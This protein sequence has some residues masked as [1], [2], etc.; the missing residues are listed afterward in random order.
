MRINCLVYVQIFC[1]LKGKKIKDCCRQVHS[2]AVC[3]LSPNSH[4]LELSLD[5]WIITKWDYSKW[6]VYVSRAVAIICSRH[7]EVTSGHWVLDCACS[8]TGSWLRAFWCLFALMESCDLQ[9]FKASPTKIFKC[10]YP[11]ILNYLW[12]LKKVLDMELKPPW[13]LENWSC[14]VCGNV[15]LGF[16]AVSPPSLGAF[17]LGT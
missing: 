14:Y 10:I 2:T 16:R 8:C 17:Q 15:N 6:Y 7:E 3:P 12:D 4:A 9:Q 1:S 11:L 13:V 5:L